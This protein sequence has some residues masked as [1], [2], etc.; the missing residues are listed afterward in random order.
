MVTLSQFKTAMDTIKH[1]ESNPFHYS[2]VHVSEQIIIQKI[3]TF[4]ISPGTG[5][6]SLHFLDNPSFDL[7]TALGSTGHTKEALGKALLACLDDIDKEH[8][9]RL[10]PE[11]AIRIFISGLGLEEAL[12]L[13]TAPQQRERSCFIS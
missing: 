5:L 3:N 10:V 6:M 1:M 2:Y 8:I 13:L 7:D 4:M 9:R 12:G 11:N